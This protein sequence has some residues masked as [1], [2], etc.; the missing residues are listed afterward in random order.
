MNTI[1]IV[2]TLALLL[3]VIE[4]WIPA[5]TLP[6]RS[7]WYVRMLALNVAQI[8]VA[9]AGANTW[10][11]WLANARPWSNTMH[12]VA[13]AM[14]GYLTITFVYY[15][16]HRARHEVPLLWRYLHQVHHSA[17]RIEVL[18]SFYKH[19]AEILLNGLLSSALLFVVVGLDPAT[20]AV[21]VAITG[22]AELLYHANLKTPYWLGF[23]FQRPESHRVHHQS[24]W[25]RQNYSDLPLWDWLFG[26]LNNPRHTVEHCGFDEEQ[27][28]ALGSLLRGKTP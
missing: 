11:L 4:R 13:A 22:I 18:T 20:A 21:V 27:E 14:L 9:Y 2:A 17:A 19:P 12:P 28:R 15:W 26:T 8:L 1:L 3:I 5:T 25:H 7:G 24:N 10:D 23:V 16:W 6:K